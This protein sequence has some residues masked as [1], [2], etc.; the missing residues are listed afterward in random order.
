MMKV[1]SMENNEEKEI[2]NSAFF[3]FIR[4]E[5]PETVFN[6]LQKED[7]YFVALVFS[8]ISESMASSI[9][10]KFE[11]ERQIK[12][13]EQIA[14]G[15]K[16]SASVIKAYEESFKE[17][18]KN[19]TEEEKNHIAGA[20]K[21]CKILQ[22]SKISVQK[23]FMDGLSKQNDTLAAKFKEKLFFFDDIPLLSDRALQCVLR[24]ID[25]NILAKALKTAAEPTCEKFYRNMSEKAAAMLKEDMEFLGPLRLKDALECQQLIVNVVLRLEEKGEIVIERPDRRRGN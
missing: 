17:S 8:C 18:L 5:N 20:D 25:E 4:A 15:L 1:D 21:A 3:D 19:Q 2:Q 16:I 14:K 23:E 11:L 6:T 10:A 7:D 9:F 13:Q 24:E 22:L 12:I